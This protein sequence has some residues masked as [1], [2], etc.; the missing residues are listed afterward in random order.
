MK[1]F[2]PFF[3]CFIEDCIS[4]QDTDLLQTRDLPLLDPFSLHT[5]LFL[6]D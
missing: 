4:F 2:L 1:H 6:S 5:P 3:F